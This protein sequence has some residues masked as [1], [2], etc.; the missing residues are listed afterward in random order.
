MGFKPRK[1]QGFETTTFPLGEQVMTLK[2]L[3]AF[4]SNPSD[5]APKGEP[6]F[7]LVWADS[8]G[9]EFVEYPKIPA[10]FGFNEKSTFWNR[11]A[12]LAGKTGFTDEDVAEHVNIE[13]PGTD[14]LGDDDDPLEAFVA[15]ALKDGDEL[16]TDDNGKNVKVD[17]DVQ[18]QGQSLIGRKCRLVMGEK[19]NKK[20]EVQPGN[21]VSQNGALPLSSSA[22]KTKGGKPAPQPAAAMP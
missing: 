19:K 14:D 1:N 13:A 20:G 11:M 5:W 9:D 16:I 3:R 21:K 15:E 2:S 17:I 4:W 12:A 18:Y 22:G 10:G 6:T 7:I 8:E